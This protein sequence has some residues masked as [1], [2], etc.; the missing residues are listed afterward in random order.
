MQFIAEW[1]PVLLVCTAGLA[2]AAVGV[3]RYTYAVH[4]FS[5]S[6]L[7]MHSTIAFFAFS[8]AC[9]SACARFGALAMSYRDVLSG[10]SFGAIVG[11]TLSIG[12]CIYEIREA[13]H[14]VSMWQTSNPVALLMIVR[15]MIVVSFL[16]EVRMVIGYIRGK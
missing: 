11:G 2:I 15:F 6:P 14:Y 12:L 4:L 5:Q 9:V 13:G 10:R 16:L 8:V 3:I 7:L 1:A